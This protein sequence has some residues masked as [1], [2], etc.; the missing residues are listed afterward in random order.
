MKQSF[1][2]TDRDYQPELVVSSGSVT[3]VL[4]DNITVRRAFTPGP[5]FQFDARIP[6]RMSGGPIL[7]GGGI[8]TKG[9]IS[10]SLG[11]H[12]NHAS[13]CM[14]APVMS[15]PLLDG[16]SLYDLQTNGNDGIVQ[17]RGEGL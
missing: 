1:R 5:H 17:V 15:L 10:S 7:V 3:E 9:V 14:I 4:S 2:V 13:G 12:E 11:A 16:K 8:L 6:G